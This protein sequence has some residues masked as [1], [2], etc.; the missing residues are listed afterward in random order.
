MVDEY[1]FAAF[2]LG[3][4]ESSPDGKDDEEN[5]AGMGRTDRT[6]LALRGTHT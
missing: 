4:C 3:S 5:C 6:H 2:S 1:M